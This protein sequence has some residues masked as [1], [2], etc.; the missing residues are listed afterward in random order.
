VH[1]DPAPGPGRRDAPAG[2]GLDPA[3]AR[4]LAAFPGGV[5][6]GA[7]LLDPNVIRLLRSTRGLLE[8]T[9]GTMPS[10]DRVV[11][12]DRDIDVGRPQG[13]LRVRVYAPR[14]RRP[15]GPAV[16]FFHGGAFVLG[17][18]YAEE[19]R[20]LRYAADA[21]CVV[22]SVGYRL[23]PEDPFPAGFDD[24]F[25]ALE[26][27]VAHA[28]ELAV[29][30]RRVAVAGN[31]AG[32]A[33]AAAV[34]LKARDRGGPTLALQVLVYPVLDD[35]MDTPSMRA[36]EATP[37]WTRTANAH[38][39]QHYLG[40]ADGRGEVS[41][42]AAPARAAEVSGLAP[43]Y[44][45]TAELD[46]LRDEGIGYAQRLMAAGVAVEVHSFAG[47]CHGFDSLAW[48]SAIGRRALDEQVDVL[49]RGLAVRP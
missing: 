47:A 26:W 9:G 25:A 18:V 7:N 29:D 4:A 21:G 44:V 16:V 48:G 22:V 15:P 11:I 17:D 28:G 38:M 12:E 20:C 49:V 6:P 45:M 41:P 39:W 10:D 27:T 33:L 30:P 5:D 43:A 24:C 23:A 19:H 40:P 32:G 34:A 2:P 13:A 36:F 37:L 35:A 14:D 31:S 46:P 1:S 42:Y 8:V 3:L